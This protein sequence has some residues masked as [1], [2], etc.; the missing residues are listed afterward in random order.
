[1]TDIKRLT[2]KAIALY[3]QLGQFD[4][5][6][7]T[8]YSVA[9]GAPYTYNDTY[10]LYYDENSKILYLSLFGLHGDTDVL[11]CLEAV[12][13]RFTPDQLVVTSPTKLPVVF[14]TYQCVNTSFD[15]D[16]QLY[17]PTFDVTLQGAK[18]KELRYR[19]H[20]AV[21]RGY[22]L[23]VTRTVTPAHHH[24]I[25]R[26]ECKKPVA[27]WDHQLYL[28]LKEYLTRFQSP[29]LFNVFF[30]DVLIG[31]DLIDFLHDTMSVP[32]GFYLQQPSVSD[33]ILSEE[34]K[35][36][37]EHAYTWLD[38]GWA[39]NPGVEAFKSKWMA[40]PRFDIW[41]YEYKNS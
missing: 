30:H 8:L 36:A 13:K 20:H 1:M 10:I 3:Q 23:M 19:V 24:I 5:H 41:T 11:Q 29:L 15:R 37:T 39:C 6:L 21:K 40:T 22:I 33:F 17:L 7:I 31:F 34:I 28:S 35:Y 2:Q 16:Y 12:S 14:R 38:L 32:V 9:F 4:E 26:H 25:A 27:W 18:Y